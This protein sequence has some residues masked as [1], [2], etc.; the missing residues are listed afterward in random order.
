[1]SVKIK[2][3]EIIFT[4]R[5]NQ[6]L[7]VLPQTIPFIR[8]EN[9]DRRTTLPIQMFFENTKVILLMHFSVCYQKTKNCFHSN[10][11]TLEIL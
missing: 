5:V 11:C 9:H 4:Q 6:F 3:E 7:S 8:V 1:M 10:M 2:K